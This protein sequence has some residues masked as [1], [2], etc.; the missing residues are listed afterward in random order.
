MNKVHQSIVLLGFSFAITSIL[1]TSVGNNVFALEY[2][3]EKCGVSLQHPEEWKVENDDYLGEGLR[4]FINIYPY[5]DDTSNYISLNIW[6]ISKNREQTIEYLSQVFTPEDSDDI[7]IM[8]L[9]NDIIQLGQHPTQKLAYSE[10][11]QGYKTYIKDI[12]ILAFDK[13]YQISLSAED[14]DTFYKYS[15]MVDELVDSLKISKPNFEGINC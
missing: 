6:D 2:T 3:N 13:L 7:K 10:E 1:I 12:N 11:F 15:S 14:E 9:E 4:S 5:P 8:I